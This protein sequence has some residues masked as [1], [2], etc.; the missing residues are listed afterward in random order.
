MMVRF[1][2]RFC[3]VHLPRYLSGDLSD[4]VRRRVARYIDECEDC[5][6]EYM[7]QREFAHKLQRSLPTL[8]RPDSGKLEQIWT[9]L[10]ED[11]S[12]PRRR[13]PSF[14]DYGSKASL[15]FGYGLVVIAI[16]IALLLPLMTAQRASLLS[17]ALPRA[18]HFAAMNPTSAPYLSQLHLPGVTAQPSENTTAPMLQNTPSPKL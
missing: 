9:S 2:Y 16:F 15:Q 3:Q 7:R 12:E 17:M 18:P 6:R 10:Q 1:K 13:R 14:K 5:Y 4:A 8:G 11:L